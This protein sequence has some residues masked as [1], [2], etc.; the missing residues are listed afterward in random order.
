MLSFQVPVLTDAEGGG[1]HI[2]AELW[3][4]LETHNRV[5]KYVNE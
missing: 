2:Q 1:M 5:I 4:S 3:V